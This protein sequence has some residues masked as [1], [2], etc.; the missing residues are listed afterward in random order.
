MWDVIAQVVISRTDILQGLVNT[1]ATCYFAIQWN[2]YVQFYHSYGNLTGL[3]LYL[4]YAWYGFKVILEYIY[5]VPISGTLV[6]CD[7]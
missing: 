3:K 1:K 2:T 7:V 5:S 6:D 4:S